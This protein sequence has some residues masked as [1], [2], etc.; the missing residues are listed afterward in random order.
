MSK[1][2][3]GTAFPTHG[4]TYGMTLRDYFAAQALAVVAA[5]RNV[6]ESADEMDDNPNLPGGAAGCIAGWAYEIADAML[7]ERSKE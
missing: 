1:Q 5:Y 6:R 2:D 3:G 7:A 4:Y